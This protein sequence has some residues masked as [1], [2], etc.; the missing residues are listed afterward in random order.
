MKLNNYTIL[1][2]ILY[3]TYCYHGCWPVVLVLPT[4]YPCTRRIRP[5]GLPHSPPSVSTT[6]LKK[7]SRSHEHY[8]NSIDR[9]KFFLNF[10]QSPNK[11]FE[12]MN[13]RTLVQ[14][15]AV[16]LMIALQ[17]ICA[18]STVVQ[19]QSLY[20]DCAY[21]KLNPS[22]FFKGGGAWLQLLSKCLFQCPTP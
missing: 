20:V 19:S 12:L 7:T 1:H 3:R 2:Y 13:A 21:T 22:L 15:I 5:S 16:L 14:R 17:W 11:D 18:E 9:K 10:I 4:S 8:Y 6:H